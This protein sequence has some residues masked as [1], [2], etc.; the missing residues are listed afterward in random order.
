MGVSF[1]EMINTVKFDNNEL[2]KRLMMW[3]GIES[4]FVQNLNAKAKNIQYYTQ[5]YGVCWLFVS[6]NE[7]YSN[8]EHE[9]FLQATLQYVYLQHK[10]IPWFSKKKYTKY[11]HMWSE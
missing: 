1:Y 2:H 9:S 11:I 8:H 4:A 6:K 10:N 5:Y 7:T 3:R